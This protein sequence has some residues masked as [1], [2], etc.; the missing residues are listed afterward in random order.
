MSAVR[1]VR[2]GAGRGSVARPGAI[3]GVGTR[4]RGITGPAGGAVR[5]ASAM[6]AVVHVAGSVTTASGAG[7]AITTTGDPSRGIAAARGGMGRRSLT[8][9]AAARRRPRR[10]RR[11]SGG[12]MSIRPRRGGIG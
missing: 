9:T 3:R 7:R 1:S 6:A 5:R 2:A 4:P 10:G 12:R 8:G 11:L